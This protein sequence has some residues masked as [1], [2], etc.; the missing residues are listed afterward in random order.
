M[1]AKLAVLE[2]RMSTHKAEYDSALDRFSADMANLRAEMEKW[3]ARHARREVQ[4]T[5]WVIGPVIAAVVV[6]VAII[7]AFELL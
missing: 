5:R 4:N 2:E 1:A 7:R 3:D 6:I